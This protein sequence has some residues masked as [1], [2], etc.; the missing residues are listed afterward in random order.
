MWA[1]AL[2]DLV[3]GGASVDARANAALAS[4]ILRDRVAVPSLTQA[5]HAKDDNLI[6]ESLVALQK[7]RDE[8]AGPAV[9][10]LAHDLDERIQVTALETIGLLRSTESAPDVRAALASGRN[11]KVKRAALE[12]LAMLGQP[13]DRSTF[14]RDVDERDVELRTA[15]LEGLGRIREP[16]DFPTLE[17]AFDQG[18][19][20]SRIHLAAAFGMVNQG[21]VSTG[22]FDPLPFLVENL[23]VRGRSDT[24]IA[25]LAELARK[26]DVRVGLNGVLPQMDKSQ[27]I[28]LCRA[29][30]QSRTPD[31]TPLLQTLAKDPDADVVTAASK[32]MQTIQPR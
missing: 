8:S 4:G 11:V 21:K 25:Y 2:S 32:A 15:A 9:S 22:E 13:Q 17:K 19:I 6:F 31:A 18:E 16:E 3:S 29:L 23:R 24:A 12:T 27:K 5:L 1:A 26:E 30:E 10:F 28:A 14:L 20:D 7:I